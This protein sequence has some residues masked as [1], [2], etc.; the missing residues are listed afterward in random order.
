MVSLSLLLLLLAPVALASPS[1]CRGRGE[2]FHGT[3]VDPEAAFKLPPTFDPL[4]TP[5]SFVLMG[6]GIQNYTCNTNG[7]PV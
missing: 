4:S 6:F 3:C 7:T 2:I 5:P 1:R